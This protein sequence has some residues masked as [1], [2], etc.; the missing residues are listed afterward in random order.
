MSMRRTALLALAASLVAV[1]PARA[2]DAAAV[3]AAASRAMGVE[4]LRTVEYTATGHDFALGQSGVPGAPWPKF[5]NPRYTRAVDFQASASRVERVRVQGE[6]P[7]FGGGQ[8]PIQGEQQQ[9]QTIVVAQNTPWAQQLEIL[10]LPHGFLRAAPTRSPTVR[11]D[12]AYSVVS[13]RGDN[14]AQVSGWIDAQN[15]VERV[16]TMIDNAVMGDMPFEAIYSEYRT[17]S[18]VLFPGRI[19]QKQGGFP[20]FD[21][22]VGDVRVNTAV[23]IQPP[24]QGGRGGGG[25]G[26]AGGGGRGGAAAAAP[27]TPSEQLAPGVYVFTGGYA[28]IAV[29]MGDHILFIE[30]GNSEARAQQVIA[31]AK[32]LMPGKPVR[33]IVNTH[34]HFDHASGL[35][36]FVAEGATILTHEWNRPYLQEVLSRP[37]T[38]SPD[39]QERA[40]R[41]VNV[42]AVPDRHTISG[43]G[44]TI[45]LYRMTEFGH[46]PGMLVAYL[47]QHRI[48]YEADMYNAV[49]A[50]VPPPA[51]P[52]PYNL[53]LLANIERLGLRVDRIVPTHYPPDGRVVTVGELRRMVGQPGS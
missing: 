23:N 2:Q 44:H 50:D 16:E 31:E 9:Q 46:T 24:Q 12:G 34:H 1:A 41:P 3:I 51:T 14:G 26:A 10:M 22:A 17:V 52:S 25:G 6:L 49:A 27:E 11:R 29:D 32:R 7:P 13:F 36:A 5:I 45:E 28:P 21:L 18:G 40:R 43:N 19:V 33:F 53:A 8:Q 39:A 42:Q 47:P 38:L 4:T 20:I 35:R 37:H 48:L 30:A 15:R